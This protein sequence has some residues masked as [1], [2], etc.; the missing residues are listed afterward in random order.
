MRTVP[1]IN[2]GFYASARFRTVV[3]E[4]PDVES[5]EA[6]DALHDDEMAE[7]VIELLAGQVAS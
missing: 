5:A 1:V 2:H 3:L 7:R 4:F 6:Y